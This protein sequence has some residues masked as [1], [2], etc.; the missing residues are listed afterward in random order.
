M[1][2]TTS[3]PTNIIGYKIP[4]DGTITSLTVQTQNSV[5]NCS[6]DVKKNDSATTLTSI[7]L[8]TQVSNV[9]DNLNIDVDQNDWL[10][11]FLQVN[12]GNVDYPL[13][14]LELAWR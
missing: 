2:A 3:I 9:V 8:I 4:R 7:T 6:F 14:N 12:S 11:I 1:K 13:L 10:Q 5:T